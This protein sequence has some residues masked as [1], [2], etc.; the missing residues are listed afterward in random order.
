MDISTLRSLVPGLPALRFNTALS[1]LLMGGSLWSVQNEEAGSAQKGMGKILA[2]L[3]LLISLLTLSEY[4][5]GWNLGI[6]EL[7]LRDVHSA[8]NLLPGRMSPIAVLCSGLSSTALLV[9]GS[10][11]SQYFSVGV[12]I[13]AIVAIMDFLFDFRGLLR[14]PQNTYSAVQT[15]GTFLVL[16]LAI[17]AARPDRGMM[18]ILSSSLPGSKAM[19]LLL[20]LIILL[21]VMMGANGASGYAQATGSMPS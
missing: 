12:F 10:R 2:G 20:P 15:A 21:T 13:L 18:K 19:R 14:N 9:M 1:F 4:L 16:S 3:A 5:F 11:I 17:L 7:F 6:D 8:P